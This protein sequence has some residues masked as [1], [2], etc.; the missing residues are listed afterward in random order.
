MILHIDLDCFFVTA[1][2]IKNPSLYGKKV[3]IIGGSDGSLFDEAPSDGSVI[4][5]ASYEARKY[6]ICSAMP[7]FQA[8]KL[9]KDLIYVKK[10]DRE[11]YNELSNKLYKILLNFTPAVEKFSI[12]EYFLDISGTSFE[13]DAENFAKFLQKKI[14]NELNLDC[15][16]GISDVK[17]IAKLTTDLSK[18]FGVGCILKKDIEVKLK[19]VSISKFTGVGKQSLKILHKYGIFTISDALKSKEIFKKLGKNGLWIWQNLSGE[20]SDEVK[21]KEPRKSLAMA[22]TF[23]Q[24]CDRSELKR[25][26]LIICRHLSFDIYRLNLNPT[27]FEV[28]IKYSNKKTITHTQTLDSSFNEILLKKISLELFEKCDIFT[29]LPIIYLGINTTNFK[30]SKNLDRN[31]FDI[32]DDKKNLKINDAIQK[33]REK[34]GVNSLKSANEIKRICD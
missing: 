23:S 26:L 22:R 11:F 29:D 1:A 15:S 13:N 25:R 16:I 3:V 34:Y 33:I 19:D 21:K 4:L 12:D 10:D 27:R 9:C 31:L 18:P 14:K 17:F 2:R 20:G 7:V 8:K 32:G 30:E 24:I 6:G 28:K 5:S